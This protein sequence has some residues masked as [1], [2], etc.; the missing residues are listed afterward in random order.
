MRSG[1]AWQRE[2]QLA[3]LR[4]GFTDRLRGRLYAATAEASWAFLVR[5]RSSDLLHLL[6]HDVSRAGQG[7][8]HVLQG[9]V[10]VTFV[11]AQTALAAAIS[12]PVA[13]AMLLV[14]AALLV[15]AGPLMG[16]SRELGDR[17][18]A[19]GRSAH[20]GMTEFLG[21][22]KL[23]KSEGTEGRHVRDFT[24]AFAALRRRQ[25]DFA[26]T[27]AAARTIFNLG[28]VAALA[29]M[30]WIGARYAGLNTPELAV[31]ALIAVRVLPALLR[32]QQDAQQFAHTLPAWEN[33]V[34]TEAALRRAAEAPAPPGAAPL[35]LARK[36]AVRGVTFAYPAAMERPALDG[37]SLDVPAH[38][39]V[40]VTGPSGAGKT[41]LADL[42]LGLIEPDAGELR[43]DG[44]ALRGPARRRW[45]RS[46]AYVPQDPHLFHETLRANLLR[47]RP[48]ATDAELRRSLR[49]AA[50]DGFVAALPEGLDTVA[51][52]RG[53]RLS[54]G[55]RQRIVLARALLREPAL[56]LLDEA[57]GQLDA[58][59]ERRLLET[60]RSLRSRTT[61]VAV[62]H[63]PAVLEAADRVVRLEAGRV[64]AGGAPPEPA[65][66]RAAAPERT[67][68]RPAAA[69][70]PWF[71]GALAVLLLAAG[72]AA[73]AQPPTRRTSAP[74]RPGGPGRC[75]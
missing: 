33:A 50:A 5:R 11:L 60:L 8:L 73:R 30:V 17:L 23:A 75:T 22:L 66:P 55:Q 6:T 19:G 46:V 63:R 14:G 38:S 32:L 4:L 37:V 49:Q 18:T 21:G 26:R 36:L 16:R 47:A 43:V 72:S 68:R 62:T 45:R 52:D 58:D 57:T 3:A 42:L 10:G 61:I 28:A 12:P 13:F 44:V 24:R 15:A 54:G 56:L 25:L 27:A 41:T 64:A 40:A 9:S 1:V 51:G 29:A 69:R 20:A 70:Q 31:M 34:A 67:R 59:T 71:A 7:A 2:T 53:G 35:P 65:S 39:L 74:R 48:D